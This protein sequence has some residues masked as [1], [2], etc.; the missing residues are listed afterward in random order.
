MLCPLSD[1]NNNKIGGQKVADRET[2]I[3]TGSGGSMGVIAGIAIVLLIA[4]VAFFLF[5]N[6]GGG[7][8]T[9]DVDV[10]AVTVDVKP[11]GQ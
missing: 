10:P 4:V 8:R 11:D 6:N 5:N 9:I 3:E 2:I 7:S 1:S